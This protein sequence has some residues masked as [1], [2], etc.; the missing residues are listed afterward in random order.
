MERIIL[1]SGPVIVENNCVLLDKHGDDLFWKFCGGK[2]NDFEHDLMEHARRKAKEEMG[3]D[4]I[5]LNQ[6]AYVMHTTKNPGSD[7]PRVDV[8]LSHFLAKRVGEISPGKDIHEWKWIPIVELDE[9][10]KKGELAPNILPTLK[11]FGFL[12]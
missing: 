10:E 4:L 6:R 1:A 11:H 5:I 8:L 9:L 3:I 12:K 2:V 7:N